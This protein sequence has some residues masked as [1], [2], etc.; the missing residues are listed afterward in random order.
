M[1]KDPRVETLPVS[2]VHEALSRAVDAERNRVPMRPYNFKCNPFILETAEAICVKNATTLPAF[3]RQCA[4]LLVADYA[5]P[6]AI[7]AQMAAESA[8]SGD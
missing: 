3:F 2:N 1:H 5:G 8:K 4:E 6:K 7:A